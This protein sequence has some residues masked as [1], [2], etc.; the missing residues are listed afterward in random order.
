MESSTESSSEAGQEAGLLA[1]L[2][3]REAAEPEGW[4]AGAVVGSG[5]Q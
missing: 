2:P 5:G 1:G 3:P 4:G